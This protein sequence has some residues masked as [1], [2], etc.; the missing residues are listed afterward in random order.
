MWGR[1]H[2]SFEQS[3]PGPRPEWALPSA[4]GARVRY[5]ARWVVPILG[6][7]MEDAF[8]DVEGGRIVAVAARG[9]AANALAAD[10]TPSMVHDLGHVAILPAFVNAHT[11]L[12]LSALRGRVPPVAVMADW[13]RALMRERQGVTPEAA[14]CAVDQAVQELHA[15]GVAAIGE[16][17]NSLATIDA[18][19]RSTLEWR[20]FHELLG[21]RVI[22]GAAT[23]QREVARWPQLSESATRTVELA[24]HAPYSTSPALMAAVAAW[25]GGRPD[26]RTTIHLGE[27]AEE[28][29]FLREGTGPWRE[30]L[31]ALGVWASDWEIPRTDPVSYVGAL[32]LLGPRTLVVHGV[33]FDRDAIT[34]VK[35]SGA[36]VVL[37]PRSNRW[38]GAGDPPLRA[39]YES[40]I[41]AAMGTDSLASV[42]DLGLFGEMAAA[43]TMAPDV[44]AS[45]LLR[46]A[47]L[48]GAQALGFTHLGAIE[49]G[50]SS[51]LLAVD[52]PVGERDVEQYLVSG[53]DRAAIRWIGE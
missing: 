7:P 35:S 27:S 48:G 28:V 23:V 2:P 12:E 16:V 46:A 24:A 9:G 19:S 20:A 10:N 39:L 32:G 1:V 33:Q 53:V 42:D 22:D 49:P 38:T 51:A 47:T 52:V 34:R 6:Q 50:R 11:H 25:V 15:W 21:F 30:L 37:C 36:T 4:S 13:V 17:T 5:R 18:L 40:G 8:V 41:A 44:P 3:Q 43:R 29:M 31:E 14:S 26:R 45:W